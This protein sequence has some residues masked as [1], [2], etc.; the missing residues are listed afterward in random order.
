[1]N[2][3]KD[4]DSGRFV[5]SSDITARAERYKDHLKATRSATTCNSYLWAVKNF[6]NFLK[7][8][9]LL[10]EDAGIGLLED[11]VVWLSKRQVKPATTH[12]CVI[13]VID[14]TNWCRIH[15]EKGC[16]QFVRPKLPKVEKK[17][18]QILTQEQYVSFI[19]EVI[20][21]N[22][23]SKTALLIMPLCGLRVNELCSLQKA[24]LVKNSGKDGNPWTLF[25]I[26]GKGKK[27]RLAP[28]L[29]DGMKI[30]SKYFLDWRV[31]RKSPWLFPGK[32]R[33]G[34][35]EHLS[36]KTLQAHLR[37]I[38]KTLKLTDD[39]TP[40]LLRRTCFTNLHRKGVPLET[41]AWIAGHSNVNTTM[42]HYISMST[43]NVLTQLDTA[44][45][46]K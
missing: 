21:L 17:I 33:N 16:K 15:E 10:L 27:E 29:P 8:S 26:K 39:L 5:E 11:F 46:R 28:L 25:R 3:N 14:Y 40:H 38:R 4:E 20:K 36:P 45:E 30:L 9:N 31:F 13:A 22:E 19:R 35:Q 41:I 32:E 6:E 44:L 2:P 24:N 43:E 7:E 34:N 12:L 37:H 23:P 18:P 1:M 42:Q